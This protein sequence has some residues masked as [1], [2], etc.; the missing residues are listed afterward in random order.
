VDFLGGK[1]KR[2]TFVLLLLS[3]GLV[4][5]AMATPY[6]F[7]MDNL[8]AAGDDFDYLLY[9]STPVPQ[10]NIVQVIKPGAD[11]TLQAPNMTTN[12]GAVTGDDI[13]VWANTMGE[14]T[15]VDGAFV[16]GMTGYPAGEAPSAAFL[17]AGQTYYLRFW[18]GPTVA[19]VVTATPVASGSH[20]V[21][22]GPF[23]APS[24]AGAEIPFVSVNGGNSTPT[25][26]T[27]GGGPVFG[28]SWTAG[29]TTAFGSSIIGTPVTQTVTI[30]NTGTTAL[31]LTTIATTGDFT[32][33]GTNGHVVAAGGTYPIIVTFN[34][35]ATGPLTGTFTITH[36]AGGSPFTVNLS[37]TGLPV[38]VPGFT[39]SINGNPAGSTFNFGNVMVGMNSVAN[40]VVTNTGTAPLH[41]NS[42]AVTGAGFTTNAVNGQIVAVGGNYPFTATF[43]PTTATGYSGSLT[44]AHDAVGNPFMVNFTGTGTPIPTPN[45]SVT[46]AGGAVASGSTITF[47]DLIIGNTATHT[48]TVHNTGTAN[49]TLSSLLATG[50]YTENGVNGTVVTPGTSADVVI[51]FAPALGANAGSFE[52]MHNASGSP[53]LINLAGNGLPVPVPVIAVTINGAPAAATYDFGNIMIGNTGTA[54]FVV[55]NTGTAPLHLNGF[56][57]A[58]PGY[59]TNATNQT[60]AV[61]GNYP[62]TVTFTPTTTNPYPGSLSFTHDAA[63][64]P[65][66]V[67]FTG[68]GTPIPTPIAT[69][70]VGGNPAPVSYDFGNVMVGDNATVDVMIEN[71]GTA[72][73]DVHNFLA[74]TPFSQNGTDQMITPGN[75][76]IVTVTFAPTT[77]GPFNGDFGF[78]HD[79]AST[80]FLM[81]LTGNATPVPVPNMTV[82][83]SG[84]DVAPASLQLFGAVNIGA[85]A[86]KTFVITNTGT[87]NLVV[88]AFQPLA[89]EWVGSIS[90]GGVIVP[91]GHMDWI[92]SFLPAVAGTRTGIASFSTNI[93]TQPNF[94]FNLEGTGVVVDPWTGG[95][96]NPN[97]NP[98]PTTDPWTPVYPPDPSV[99]G[100]PPV[101]V[102][103]PAPPLGGSNPTSL[104]VSYTAT[105]PAALPPVPASNVINRY[106]EFDAVGGS[107]FDAT[108]DLLFTAADLPA[109]I[110]DPITA[111]PPLTVGSWSTSLN[112]W[113][114]YTPTIT[115]V[116]TGIW[117]AHITGVWHFSIFVIGTGGV[118]PVT[119]LA[120]NAAG[121]DNTVTIGWRTETEQNNSYFRIER[122]LAGSANWAEL[123]HTPSAA[124]A[125][126]SAEPLRYTFVDRTVTNGQTYTYRISSVDI[127]GRGYNQNITATA[128]PRAII[129]DNYSLSNYPNPFNPSTR[130]VYTLKDAGLVHL[131]ITNI[132][133]QTVTTLVNGARMNKGSNYATWNASN[134]PSG[135]Y[136][137]R[138]EVNGFS[139][140]TKLVLSK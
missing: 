123:T 62:F 11:N 38:P 109:G 99:G 35:T 113:T 3:L 96:P 127:N 74:N 133:G 81:A 60:V 64:S 102:D 39:V 26:A 130:I 58:G 119:S 100:V 140:M 12:L 87:A 82:T 75:H 125:G 134:M 48:I 13:F 33:N 32:S 110:T 45:F 138:L 43:A 10:G 118:L 111:V 80:A 59:T 137:V 19:D 83:E 101:T 54:N 85:S 108:I 44:I 122:T 84:T 120:M 77:V 76:I 55:S 34:P 9:Q 17:T 4:G 24:S 8:N 2:L 66:G 27:V 79:P 15:M 116:G 37:G 42:F 20:Y 31:T 117:N 136:F 71:T 92:I 41:L 105:P 47:A 18:I 25:W 107:N 29:S 104:S 72:D 51:T 1:M 139:T 90:A 65:F 52:I 70:T 121:G 97:P 124:Q 126:N 115:L 98:N 128:T 57:A 40:F 114:F 50:N 56:V 14:G 67:N 91:G 132:M 69:I 53:Y 103:F 36:T 88:S 89:G 68:S 93:V 16:L 46:D 30:S 106:F 6:D 131:T 95:N 112:A 28:A 94:M 5:F 73:L 22:A 129:V 23:I 135:I 63:G 78:A 21:D 86:S 61:G 7:G 49:L